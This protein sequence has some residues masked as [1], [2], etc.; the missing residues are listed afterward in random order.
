[1]PTPG[2]GWFVVCAVIALASLLM[3]PAS[4]WALRSRV[5]YGC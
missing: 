2:P 1:M 4:D 5:R 3:V